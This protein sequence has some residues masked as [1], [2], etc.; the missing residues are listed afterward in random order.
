MA[1][2][3]VFVEKLNLR[4]SGLS[5]PF[6]LTG[7]ERDF[8][9]EDWAWE[10]LRLSTD[11]RDAYEA[12]KAGERLP[13]GHFAGAFDATT[14]FSG[15]IMSDEVT[16]RSRFGLST[17]LDPKQRLPRLLKPRESWFYPLSDCMNLPGDSFLPV[18]LPGLFCPRPLVPF[19]KTPRDEI[20]LIKDALLGDASPY[21]W[22]AID[23]SVPP[24]AKIATAEAIAE[25]RLDW[26]RSRG[27][28]TQ[29]NSV[30]GIAAPIRL[31]E[32]DKFHQYKFKDAERQAKGIDPSELWFAIRVDVR[33]PIPE[34]MSLL[35]KKLVAINVQLLKEGKAVHF[36]PKRLRDA[37]A[38][39]DDDAKGSVLSDGDFL[40]QRAICAQLSLAGLTADEIVTYV[41]DHAIERSITTILPGSKLDSWNRD[42]KNRV[43]RYVDDGVRL[44]KGDFRRLIH[45]QR[46]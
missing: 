9:P 37:F 3:Q 32:C 45:A 43:E 6:T 1:V 38:Q 17:W 14:K 44:V 10:F 23:C 28:F 30:V 26:L 20:K 33:K 5:S 4:I 25:I 24:T 29:S 27:P 35:K 2:D 36:I 7:H 34:Q 22:F 18:A 13:N 15:R 19:D 39:P 16:C 41:R 40:K 12:A 11:Y 46:P 42:L 31:A 8:G 21:V